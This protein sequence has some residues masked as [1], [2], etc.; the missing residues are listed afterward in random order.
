MTDTNVHLV[1]TLTCPA[2]FKNVS[3]IFWS[4]DFTL[5]R[6]R[7]NLPHV[8]VKKK[9]VLWLFYVC[10]DT[11][12]FLIGEKCLVYMTYHQGAPSSPT[13]DLVWNSYWDSGFQLGWWFSSWMGSLCRTAEEEGKQKV[14]P[15]LTQTLIRYCCSFGGPKAQC[16]LI[17]STLIYTNSRPRREALPQILHIAVN[18]HGRQGWMAGLLV[19]SC[20]ECGWTSTECMS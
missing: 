18:S 6:Y 11:D 13:G 19:N 20:H 3:I 15:L 2:V 9:R 5:Q 7:W 8:C 14:Q 16:R 17:L 1:I 10:H 12:A 4:W